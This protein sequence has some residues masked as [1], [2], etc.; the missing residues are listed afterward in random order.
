MA[1]LPELVEAY[2]DEIARALN[3]SKVRE[4]ISEKSCAHPTQYWLDAL[5]SVD[6]I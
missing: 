4:V 5:R 3:V 6:V 1:E 2:A